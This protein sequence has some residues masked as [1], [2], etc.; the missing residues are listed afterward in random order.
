M[1]K[2]GRPEAYSH[3]PRDINCIYAVQFENGIVKVGFTQNPHGRM[4][5]LRSLARCKFDSEV[6][7]FFIGDALPEAKCW[8]AWAEAALLEQVAAIGSP[9]PR[10]REYF[11]RVPFSAAVALV[12]QTTLDHQQQALQQAA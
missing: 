7:D 10:H 9:L 5:T 8:T 4:E 6:V 11:K 3:I 2:R 1:A 12:R